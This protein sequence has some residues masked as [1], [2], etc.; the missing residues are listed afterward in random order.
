[1][2]PEAD[3][4]GMTVEALSALILTKPDDLAER[5][6]Q[7]VTL[8]LRIRAAATPQELDSIKL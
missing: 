7:R 6:A 1:L 3:L 4:R 5:E 8:K 2:K